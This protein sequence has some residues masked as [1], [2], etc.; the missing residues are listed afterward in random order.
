MSTDFLHGVEVLEVTNG[1]RAVRT[2][3]TSIIGIV[4]TAKSADAEAFPLNRPVLIAASRAEAA[5][6]GS[7]GTLPAA[8]DGILDQA[9]AVVIAVRVEEG[10]TDAETLTNIIGGV[11]VDGSTGVQCL[12]DSESVTGYRPRILIAPGFT[13]EKA[14]ADELLSIAQRLRAIVVIDGPDTTDEDA[15][16]Y[17]GDFGNA[18]AYLVDPSVRVL[19][20]GEEIVEPSSPRV[21]GLIAKSD[22]DRGFWWSPSNQEILGITGTARPIDFLLGDVNSRANLLNEKNIATI[23]RENGFR[24]WGNRTLSSDPVWAFLST[25][26]TSDIIADSIQSSLMWAVDRPITRQF[27]E[28]VADTVNG[29]LRY[30][31][32]LGAILGGECWYD[33]DDNPNGELSQGKIVFRYKF[34]PPP[35]AERITLVAETVED[36]YETALFAE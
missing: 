30:L 29:Y 14:C 16:A 9:G 32:S 21:A 12:V 11:G 7:D 23:I 28:S 15:I 17:A 4:G 10:A 13:H 22:N 3:K 2:V 5:K 25:R 36:Y 8:L 26:R 35:P 19:S 34:T 1:P 24:L 20:D 31:T 18:R 27:L 33:R 6:L